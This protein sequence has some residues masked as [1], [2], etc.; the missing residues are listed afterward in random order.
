MVARDDVG[1]ASDVW[2]NDGAE[3]AAS[4]NDVPAVAEGANAPEA[5]EAGAAVEDDA[6]EVA[7]EDDATEV[8]VDDDAEVAAADDG[9]A[10]FDADA[11]D[12]CAVGDRNGRMPSMTMRAVAATYASSSSRSPRSLFRI[13][14]ACRIS[15]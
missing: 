12:E 7:A 11:D 13:C 6:A 4:D 2:A 10:E 9:T 14:C 1:S 3:A 8:A 15:A 5:D